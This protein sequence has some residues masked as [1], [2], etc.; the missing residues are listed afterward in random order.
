MIMT[1]AISAVMT[2]SCTGFLKE[3]PKTFEQ[4]GNFYN[5][6]DQIL[7]GVM[8]AYLGIR[9]PLYGTGVNQ[10]GEN[11]VLTEML[12]GY[13]ERTSS[14]F[15]ELAEILNMTINPDN[16][17]V[18]S[19]FSAM[20]TDL[21][22]VNQ[23]ID[24]L[25]NKEGID[26]IL[27]E[28]KK[29]RYLAEMY[30]L[31]AYYYSYLVRFYGPVPLKLTPTTGL[32]DAQL[33]LNSEAEVFGQ[34][35][36]DLEYA[37]SLS[38]KMEWN[39]TDGR[40]SKGTIK[41]YL[42]K[43]YLTMAGYPIHDA[44]YYDKAFAKG[45]EVVKSGVFSLYDTYDA[46]RKGY[47]TNGKE[48]L[49]SVQC[50]TNEYDNPLHMIGVP[51]NGATTFIPVISFYE[52][53]RPGGGWRP[54]SEFYN[55]YPEGDARTA[56]HAYYFTS[57]KSVDGTVTHTFAPSLYKYWDEACATGTDGKSGVNFPLIR[58]T[59]VLLTVAEAAC[60]GGST[61]DSDA[62]NAYWEVRH[63]AMPS[64]SKPS[65]ISFD[66]VFKERIWEQAFEGQNWFNMIRT[67]KAYD[68]AKDAVVDL[69]GYKAPKLNS[70]FTADDLLLPYP[71]SQVR[72]NP[73]LVR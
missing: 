1:V 57:Q 17:F 49:F 28:D 53:S 31:R 42:A 6:E 71:A 45:L 67:R 62:I 10:G 14:I 43:M 65:S 47:D 4:P 44:T 9:C 34:I 16:A 59:D 27:S 33:P 32:A 51:R 15:G 20:Y 60:K 5:N 41:A 21:E 58:Y 52:P 23:M 22:N 37:E 11:V 36:D 68:F 61:T 50:M 72:L 24:I 55:S 19:T 12:C 40:I 66:Q 8:G 30:F 38:S 64:E 26:D 13:A 46:A 7:Q 2:V 25:Q 73:N 56:N 18:G 29:S 54:C 39:Y 35:I 70:P 69:V 63:R 3:E 48:Y